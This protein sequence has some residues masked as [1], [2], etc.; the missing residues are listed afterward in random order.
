MEELKNSIEEKR[1]Q[2]A[3]LKKEL[4]ESKRKT[5]ERL[6][7]ERK[8]RMMKFNKEHNLTQEIA[9]KS[10][11]LNRELTREKAFRI[12]KVENTLYA[13]NRNNTHN[14]SRESSYS[15]R[16][17]EEERLKKLDSQKLKILSNLELKLIKRYMETQEKQRIELENLRNR[18]KSKPGTT[19]IMERTCNL[20]TAR[21]TAINL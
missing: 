17:E 20:K 6:E 3:E 16:I 1:K 4:E 13:K 5:C 19:A 12:R 14:C 10:N 7:K 8:K 9:R 2:A 21:S 15:K 18:L 11:S